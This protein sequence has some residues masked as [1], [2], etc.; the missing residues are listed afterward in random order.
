MKLALYGSRG[1]YSKR[2]QYRLRRIPSRFGPPRRAAQH[3]AVG[4]PRLPHHAATAKNTPTR[5]AAPGISAAARCA[6]GPSSPRTACRT[7]TLADHWTDLVEEVI[8]LGVSQLFF[9]D[10]EQIRFL[11]DDDTAQASLGDAIKSLLGLDLAE[12]LITDASVLESRF[13]NRRPGVKDDPEVARVARRSAKPR[14]TNC[15]RKKADRA[16]LENH[17]QRAE[18]AWKQAEETFAAIGGKHWQERDARRHAL[19]ELKQPA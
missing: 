11:A 9:F 4:D 17:R 6:S 8:P 14:R 5:S 7:S 2:C 10:A 19:A 13:T 1:N 16:A 18:N 15:E 12:R 3:G